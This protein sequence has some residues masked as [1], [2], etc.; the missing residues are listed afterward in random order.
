MD[1]KREF[2]HSTTVLQ[3]Y[4]NPKVRKM[5]RGTTDIGKGKRKRDWTKSYCPHGKKMSFCVPCGGAGICE[6]KANKY[7]CTESNGS[8]TDYTKYHCPHGKKKSFCM[9]CGGNG[10]CVHQKRKYTCKECKGSDICEHNV[11]KYE[12]RE[13][14][15][16]G[17][18]CDHGKQK[19]FCKDCGGN[20]LCK[21]PHCPTQ[22]NPK[23]DGHCCFCF[24]NLFPDKPVARNYRMKE[25]TVAIFL[26]RKVS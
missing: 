7:T 10:I 4:R 11:R 1:L 18:F 8:A 25:N 16:G 23:Y 21:T 14:C 17:R 22:K 12:C 3:Q 13:G 2:L 20:A 26:K 15:G 5:D 6:H 9:P 24:V 19:A